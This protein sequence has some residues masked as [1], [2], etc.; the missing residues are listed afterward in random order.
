MG[1]HYTVHQAAALQLEDEAVEAARF[2]H[3][4]FEMPVEMQVGMSLGIQRP[5]V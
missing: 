1:K 4:G 2:E 5:R 3:V